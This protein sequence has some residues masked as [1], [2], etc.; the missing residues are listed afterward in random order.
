MNQFINIIARWTMVFAD[1]R[2]ILTWP[3][4]MRYVKHWVQYQARSLDKLSVVDSYP[5]LTDWVSSTP[6]EPH[7]FYQGAW[8][9]RRVIATKVAK[10]VDIGSSVLTISVLSAQIETVFVDYRPLKVDLPGLT[11]MAGDILDLPFPD[12]S[13]DSLSCLHVIEHIGLGRYGDPIDPK[14]TIKAALELQRIMSRG[15][16][17]F[18]SVPI[19][20]E[21]VCFNAHRV[22]SA[23]TVLKLFPEL[24]LIEFSFVDDAGL[25]HEHQSVEI[26]SALN[27]GCGLFHFQKS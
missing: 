8:L 16:N 17:L 18:L 25:F 24:T 1:P 22:H 21:R 9:A 12:D 26:A 15:G 19:G 6:F 13:I 14:G 10:H 4:I 11:S 27:Y 7:Y 20:H 2:K 3:Y 23:M 5:C